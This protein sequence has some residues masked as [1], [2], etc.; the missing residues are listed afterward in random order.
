MFEGRLEAIYIGAVR[1][2]DLEP[3]SEVEA[4]AGKGL[5]GDRYYHQQ[6]TFS[7][8]GSVD[9]EVTLIEI[10]AVEAL[11]Q[12]CKLSLQAGQ[13]RRNL[14]TRGV[15]LNHLVGQEFRVGDVVLRG[16]RLC[17]PCGHLESLTI[18]G[19]KDS[20]IHRGGLRAQIV[21]GGTVRAGDT[22]KPLT[23]PAE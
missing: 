2:A 13:A 23:A 18:P 8:P 15:P 1:R 4:I 3:V 19:V 11:K 7:K 10:E 14:V 22:I 21:R 6:G 9:R 12:E 20:L 5:A 16:I 17:E